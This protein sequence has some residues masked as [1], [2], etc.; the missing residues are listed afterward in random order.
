MSNPYARI[1]REPGAKGFS[2]AAFLG[3]LPMAMAP[4][5]LVAMLSQAMGEYSLAGAVAVS[6]VKGCAVQS[7]IEPT[8]DLTTFLVTTERLLRGSLQDVARLPNAG[9]ARGAGRPSTPDGA[10]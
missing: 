9:T 6:F 3:R 7:L 8:L 4:I 5:G 10:P 2:A 1:F